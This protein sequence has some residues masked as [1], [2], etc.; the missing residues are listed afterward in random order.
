M[1]R[2]RSCSGH[3]WGRSEITANPKDTKDHEKGV[4]TLPPELVLGDKD[5]ARYA[6]RGESDRMTLKFVKPE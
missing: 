4:W 2:A 3:G 5:R 1:R 6:A